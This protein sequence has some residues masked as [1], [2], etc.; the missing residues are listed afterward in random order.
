M[1]GVSFPSLL[2]SDSLSNLANW[3]LGLGSERVP[4]TLAQ[5]PIVQFQPI[6]LY[7]IQQ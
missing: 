5:A 1:E 7:N 4:S 3:S 2:K 6:I